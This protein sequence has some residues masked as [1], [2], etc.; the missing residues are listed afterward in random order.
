MPSE[1]DAAVQRLDAALVEQEGFRED[2][3]AAIGT[4]HEIR[5]YARYRVTAE[6]IDAL[7][8]WLVEEP[9]DE[10]DFSRG[11]IWLSG[12]ELGGTGTRYPD[13]ESPHD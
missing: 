2:W 10:Q 12:R 6:E 11:R 8:A 5:A 13:L 7:Q 9:P 3:R 1:R 4:P